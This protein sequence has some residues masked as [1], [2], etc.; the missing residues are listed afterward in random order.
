M[1]RNSEGLPTS[2]DDGC[3]RRVPSPWGLAVLAGILAWLPIHADLAGAAVHLAAPEVR[4]TGE[5][6]VPDRPWDGLDAGLTL[7]GWLCG[8]DQRSEAASR[9]N[10]LNGTTRYLELATNAIT[11]AARAQE[12]P[13]PWSEWQV[14]GVVRPVL[15]GSDYEHESDLVG[16]TSEADGVLE[17]AAVS[18]LYV[19]GL[20]WQAER[21]EELFKKQ[22]VQPPIEQAE[23]DGPGVT[24]V[25]RDCYMR[26]QIEALAGVEVEA[27]KRVREVAER[28]KQAKAA[29]MAGRKP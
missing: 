24:Y 22:H 4:A 23:P 19:L 14:R 10:K 9:V 17:R 7:E 18:P 25:L 1:G 6:A 15:R 5:A 29:V 16:S 11:T 21:I 12:K 28:Y 2:H 3:G 8:R 20:Y 27:A 13:E 26:S